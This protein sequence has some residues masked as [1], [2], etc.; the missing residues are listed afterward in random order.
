MLPS[1][2]RTARDTAYLTL[3]FLTSIA[4]FTVWVLALSLS[5]SLALLIIGLPVVIGA[6]YVIRWTAELD[7]RNAALVFGRPVRGTYHSHHAASFGE[8]V[9]AVVRDPQVWRDLAWLITHSVLGFAFGTL[10]IALVA[11]VGGLATL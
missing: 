8:R 11:A 10:A 5:L 7:R 1:I 3:A 9:L 4:A 2:D 6:A